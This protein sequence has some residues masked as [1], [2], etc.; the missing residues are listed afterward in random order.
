MAGGR[1]N[2]QKYNK[3][4]HIHFIIIY[5]SPSLLLPGRLRAPVVILR[6]VWC[7][8][9]LHEAP[10]N[11]I[12]STSDALDKPPDHFETP[13]DMLLLCLDI[14]SSISSTKQNPVTSKW[15][16][17]IGRESVK[18]QRYL[19]KALNVNVLVM[20]YKL[21]LLIGYDWLYQKEEYPQKMMMSFMN[22]DKFKTGK[23]TRDWVVPRQTFDFL[24]W[25]GE[26]NWTVRNC[27]LHLKGWWWLPK[28]FP[29]WLLWG[30]PE[31]LPSPPIMKASHG[32]ENLLCFDSHHCLDGQPD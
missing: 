27:C 24:L 28:E 18:G 8:W 10:Q 15:D 11:P 14:F 12:N 9:F 6:E 19:A 23:V 1:Q 4:T 25:W 22:S 7:G 5:I 30:K 32:F 20:F 29:P 17:I 26:T 31:R 21:P 2:K 3:H 13:K 16:S